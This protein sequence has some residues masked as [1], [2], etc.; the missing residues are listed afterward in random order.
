MARY[1]GVL[2]TLFVL[3][4]AVAV[5]LTLGAPPASALGHHTTVTHRSILHKHKALTSIAAGIAAYHVAKKTGKNRM[6]AGRHRN[7]AQRHPF[8]TGVGAAALTHHVLKKT[9]HPRR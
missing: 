1:L 9:D 3:L 2:R 8:L 7:F 6:A 4:L 5:P